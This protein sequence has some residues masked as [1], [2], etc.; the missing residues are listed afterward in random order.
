[1]PVSAP[2]QTRQALPQAILSKEKHFL[3][4]RIPDIGHLIMMEMRSK[5]DILQMEQPGTIRQP[6]QVGI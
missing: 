2:R 1:M 4:I 6:R 3:T 5:S